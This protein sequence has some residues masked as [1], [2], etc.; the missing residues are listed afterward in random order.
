MNGVWSTEIQLTNDSNWNSGGSVIVGKDGVV[1]VTWGKSPVG[2]DSQIYYKT[3]NGGWSSE[4]KIVTSTVSD[5][6][7]SIVQD[8][9]GTLWVFWGRQIFFSLLDFHYELFDKY[10]FDNGNTWSSEAQ[11]TNMPTSVDSKMP[12]AI[13]A[14]GTAGTSLWVF[15]STNYLLNDFNI[16]ALMSSSIY[17]IHDVTVS[18]IAATPGSGT[19]WTITVTVLDLGDYSETVIVSLALYNSSSYSLGPLS[20][21]VNLGASTSIVFTWNIAGVPG[22]LYGA[23]ATVAPVP[24]QS[25]GNQGHNSLQVAGLIQIVPVVVSSTGGGQAPRHL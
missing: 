15:Y 12:S 9:N 20:G 8:R 3:F 5:E 2:S 23:T 21:F 6:H 13:Q 1:R 18:S 7:P 14:T 22:G 17:P 24:G 16:W 10:S 19:T 11:I 25:L 4:K